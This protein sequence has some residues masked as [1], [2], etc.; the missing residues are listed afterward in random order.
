MTI[1]YVPTDDNKYVQ[2][3][4]ID[5]EFTTDV[6]KW[7]S[8]GIGVYVNSPE[9]SIAWLDKDGKIM[10]G[11]RPNA[12]FVFG[13]GVPQQIIN[14]V[15]EKI[16]ELSLDEYEDIVT[17][18]GNLI[19]GDTL[20]TL[21]NAKANTGDVNT[22]LS[23]K[24]DKVTGKS[25][26]DAE[27]ADAQSSIKAAEYMEVKIDSE[28]KIL[29]GITVNGEKEIN[30]PIVLPSSKVATIDNP[31]WIEAKIDKEGRILEGITNKGKKF[32][33]EIIKD[34]NIYDVPDFY[35]AYLKEK[36]SEINNRT[37]NASINGDSFVFMTDTHIETNYC[38]SPAL[39]KHIVDNT[40]VSKVFNGGDLVNWG[41]KN[42]VIPKIRQWMN[43]FK[44][45]TLYITVGNHDIN[46]TNASA[47]E[48]FTDGEIY[49]LLL[50]HLEEKVNTNQKFYYYVDNPSQ[51]I[52]YFFLDSHWPTN[53][54]LAGRDLHYTEQ[55]A[56]METKARELGSEWSIAI[57]QHIFYKGSV[58]EDG[59]RVSAKRSTLADELIAK[60]DTM[61]DDSDMPTIIG[62]FCGHT[63]W[64]WGEYSVKGYPIIATLSDAAW[65]TM[66]DVMWPSYRARDTVNEQAFDVFTI[67]KTQRKIFATRIGYGN[68]R[69][70]TY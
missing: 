34:K 13:A 22:A 37:L 33:G 53:P 42:V 19:N 2:F 32:I 69:E 14:Y 5:N 70:F 23:T 52:R 28:K 64:D 9:F 4:C 39:V 25:L 58:I 6:T 50:K 29:E 21:L 40:S 1:R 44:F 61:A 63:H 55:L 60:L 3:R 18:L 57:I 66:G 54:D 67:D 68:N 62:V 49:D 31:E 47:A 65:T 8:C 48:Y 46:T 10:F 56:W 24:V 51:K 26:I 12:D 11:I 59:V 20:A 36:E 41:N 15:T 16:S 38:H 17:F 7:A 35:L 43:W 27:Y 30:I 45:T